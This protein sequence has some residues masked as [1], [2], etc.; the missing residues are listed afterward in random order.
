MV[1][2]IDLGGLGQ[3][4]PFR[5]KDKRSV[6]T[7]VTPIETHRNASQGMKTIVHRHFIRTK[8]GSMG[9]P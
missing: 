8:S 1:L 7:P 5:N 9:L 6:R 2:D 4:H 3:C